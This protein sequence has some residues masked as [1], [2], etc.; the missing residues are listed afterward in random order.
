MR[1]R[2]WV[3]LDVGETLIDETRVW[4]TWALAVGVPPLTL[5]AAVGAA[6]ARGG[7][8]H[9]AFALLGIDGWRERVAE[10]ERRCGPFRAAD[11]YPDA[12]P[13]L[14]GLQAAGY[15]V[16]V[17]GNQPARRAAELEALGV[18]VEVMAMSEALGAAKPDQAF[19]DRALDLLG[20]PDRAAVAYV[21]DRVDNDVRPAAEAGLRAVWLQRGPWGTLQADSGRHATLVV[22]SLAELVDRIGEAFE[23]P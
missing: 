7:F 1:A 23:R 12:L 11:L 19:F 18:D 14:R 2:R 6:I 21:G 5:H 9:D 22:G 13:A 16:A 4:S 20:L 10:V 3:C 17:V 15:R 8:D